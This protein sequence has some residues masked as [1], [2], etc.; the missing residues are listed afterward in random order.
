MEGARTVDCDKRRASRVRNLITSNKT[1]ADGGQ[2]ERMLK[3]K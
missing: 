2:M 1:K 3:Q